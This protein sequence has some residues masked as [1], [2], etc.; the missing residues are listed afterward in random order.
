M[1]LFFIVVEIWHRRAIPQL[2]IGPRKQFRYKRNKTV[3]LVRQ[4]RLFINALCTHLLLCKPSWSSELEDLVEEKSSYTMVFSSSEP[5]LS[6]VREYELV[7]PQWMEFRQYNIIISTY[8]R[9]EGQSWF[10]LCFVLGK[11]V[12]EPLLWIRSI[13]DNIMRG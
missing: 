10:N 5:F 4:I 7:S 12:E 1:P 9:F 3:S 6:P 13:D 8:Q 11:K 2:P